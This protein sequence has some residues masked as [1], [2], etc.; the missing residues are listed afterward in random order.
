MAKENRGFLFHQAQ[1]STFDAAHEE[2]VLQITCHSPHSTVPG[3]R[4]QLK[5]LRIQPQLFTP[6]AQLQSGRN[7]HTSVSQQLQN[8]AKNVHMRKSRLYKKQAKKRYN[9]IQ[10]DKKK[11]SQMESAKKKGIQQKIQELH[12]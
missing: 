1:G 8:L 12:L 4:D 11:T 6:L 7:K 9:T 3:L 10:N 5:D 2:T